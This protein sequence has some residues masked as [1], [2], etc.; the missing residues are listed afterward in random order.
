MPEQKPYWF[1]VENAFT[2]RG[3]KVSRPYVDKADALEAAYAI[4]DRIWMPKTRIHDGEVWV[5]RVVVMSESRLKLNGWYSKPPKKSNYKNG[6]KKH[7][8]TRR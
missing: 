1:V 4:H 2:P 5:G 7:D 8:I 6:R 3:A